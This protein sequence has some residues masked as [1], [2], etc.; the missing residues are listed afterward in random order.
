MK[1]SKLDLDIYKGSTYRKGFQWL[2]S[3]D[4]TPMDLTGCSIKMQMRAFVDS[5]EVLYEAST[6]N[7]KITITN[8]LEGK[9]TLLVSSTDSA[10]WNFSKAV[11]DMDITFPNQ[12]VYTVTEG[13]VSAKQQVTRNA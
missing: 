10:N 8:A 1:P 4:K 3:P 9:W 5:S 12:D 13:L 7:Q 2:T 11:Y 6:S